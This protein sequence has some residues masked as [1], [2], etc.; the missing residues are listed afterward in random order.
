MKHLLRLVSA[1]TAVAVLP[2][3]SNVYAAHTGHPPG[4]GAQ[5]AL[6]TSSVSGYLGIGVRDVPSDKVSDLKVKDTSGAEIIT[7]DHDAPAASAGLKMHDVVQQMN[8]Q[9]IANADQ[10]RKMLHETPPGRA[11]T[12]VVSRDGQPQTINV[13]LADQAQLE[14]T[15]IDNLTVVPDPNSDNG[16]GIA[17][18]AP[19]H[20]S[21]GFFGSLL[22][23]G[24]SI[25]VQLDPLNSQLADYFGVHDG[26]GLLVKRVAANSEASAAG[27]KA[28][29][30]V[31]RV[32]GRTMATVNSW[33]KALHANRGKAVQVTIF[34]NRKEQ[35]ISLQDG[36]PKKKG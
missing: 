2:L 30:V 32:N 12:L 19:T 27:L 34:R 21:Y 4:A 8:G 1:L 10:L 29:D 26:Q 28:G 11:I 24:P 18:A 36:E 5:A 35:V 7:L 31:I 22:F 20:S 16:G 17:L 3:W 6:V 15:A 9:A 25:G 13:T 14:H 33:D 23:G